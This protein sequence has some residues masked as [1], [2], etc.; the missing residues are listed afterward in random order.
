MSAQHAT[1][2][3]TPF[4]GAAG[5]FAPTALHDPVMALTMR[6]SA[7]RPKFVAQVAAHDPATVVE[8]GCG[9]GAITR[10]L[11]QA[12]PYVRIT[13]TDIDP[14]LLSRA[15]RRNRGA[16]ITWKLAPATTLPVDDASADAVVCSLV[17]HHL[18]PEPKAAAIAEARRTLRPGGHLHVADWG[19]PRDPVEG[20]AFL[21][22]R[23]VDGMAPTRQHATGALPALLRGAGFSDVTVH[24]RFRTAWGALELLS[25]AAPR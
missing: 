1:P 6:E 16:R 24:D 9:T 2:P 14:H 20:L 25:A 15:A 21:G 4:V 10:L 7:W 19:M 5:R 3:T 23:L 11:A 17:L 22:L 12:L 13:A 18:D 8:M